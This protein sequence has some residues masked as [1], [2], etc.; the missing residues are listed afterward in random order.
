M[1]H[2]MSGKI[3]MDEFFD[4]SPQE[5]GALIFIT[6]CMGHKPIMEKKNW[7]REQDKYLKKNSGD[8]LR[9]IPLLI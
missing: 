8:E 1:C 6:F 3:I 2:P 7:D 5:W 4:V 9:V